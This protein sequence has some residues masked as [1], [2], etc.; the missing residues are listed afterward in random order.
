MSHDF[1]D[2]PIGHMIRGV[3]CDVLCLLNLACSGVLSSHDRARVAVSG[4]YFGPVM[5]NAS[6]GSQVRV[7][8]VRGV[9]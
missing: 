1:Q 9:V 3:L 2:H 6:D 5:S 4:Y 8:R 7:C